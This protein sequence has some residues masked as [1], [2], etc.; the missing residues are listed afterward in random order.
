MN[1]LAAG[2][3]VLDSIHSSGRTQVKAGGLFY[4]LLALNSLKGEDD[5]IFPLTLKD[6]D[7]YE[8][9]APLYRHLKDDFIRETGRIPR[10]HLNIYDNPMTERDE[11]YESTAPG[12][13]LSLVPDPNMFDGVLINM[14]SGTDISLED[15]K[16][17]RE[18]FKGLI[19]MDIHSLSTGMDTDGSRYSR[20]I[21]DASEWMKNVDIMQAN[22]H[23][24]LSLADG[25]DEPEIA[26]YSL[27]SGL[28]CLIVTK[29]GN[30][31]SSYT[32]ESGKLAE[33]SVPAFEVQVLNRVGLGD[34][35][36]AAFFIH[37]LKTSLL[38]DSLVFANEKASVAA[39]FQ[40]T[41]K[42]TGLTNE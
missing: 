29:G 7:C 28:K 20:P 22:E 36:G 38:Q 10:V 4:S 21:P 24:V 8:Y 11:R 39:G 26:E 33:F 16:T 23:E 17:F 27:S 41:E 40:N 6:C 14:I 12:L 1:L 35:F 3:S 34:T 13:D 18:K 25:R 9:F 2:H 31:F 30:G 15:L 32:E 37:Y 42:F 19:Y 5:Q